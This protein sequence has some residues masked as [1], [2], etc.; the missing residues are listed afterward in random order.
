MPEETTN[1]ATSAGSVKADAEGDP[2]TAAKTNPAT[3]TAAPASTPKDANSRVGCQRSKAQA[4]AAS[5]QLAAMIHVPGSVSMAAIRSIT[6]SLANAAVEKCQVASTS[7]PMNEALP[8][9]ASMNPH[10]T[11]NAAVAIAATGRSAK[12]AA[13]G[14]SGPNPIA[15]ASG[16]ASAAFAVA[17]PARPRYHHHTPVPASSTHPAAGTPHITSMADRET[18]PKSAPR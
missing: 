15:P 8:K 16:V 14:P 11:W 17:S 13:R 2:Q 4:P 9:P 18:N 1:E 6:A 3:S 5:T 10:S 7:H 12:P